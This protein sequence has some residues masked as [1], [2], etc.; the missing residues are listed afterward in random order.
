MKPINRSKI[1]LILLVFAFTNLVIISQCL[2]G[3]NIQ[4]ENQYLKYILS[5]DGRN[6]GF[7]DKQ[8]G[9]DYLDK[10]SSEPFAYLI[11]DG[12]KYNSTKISV[13]N[14]K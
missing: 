9:T 10:S 1:S 8:S 13:V 6:L 11:K 2:A 4:F 5:T 14:E 3:E 7:I 12:R